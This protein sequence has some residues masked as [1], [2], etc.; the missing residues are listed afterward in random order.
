MYTVQN[1]LYRSEHQS[2]VKSALFSNTNKYPHNNIDNGSP[3][4]QA[5]HFATPPDMIRL[6][7]QLNRRAAPHTDHNGQTPL[8][9][10]VDLNH[11]EHDNINNNDDNNNNDTP[12]QLLESDQEHRLISLAVLLGANLEAASVKDTIQG[13]TPLLLLV[14]RLQAANSPHTQLISRMA[15]QLVQL[16][17]D[18]S[19]G[20]TQDPCDDPTC[21]TTREGGMVPD[22]GYVPIVSSSTGGTDQTRHGIGKT[23]GKECQSSNPLSYTKR[24]W[25]FPTE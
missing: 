16:C 9:I 21:G 22:E 24:Q 1:F 14:K 20:M 7:L 10:L 6:L 17:D 13:D 8:H 25:L 3:L 18:P 23:Q 15:M 11:E 19:M 5:C 4:H 2:A 12:S